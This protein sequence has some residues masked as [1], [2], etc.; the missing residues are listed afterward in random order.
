MTKFGGLVTDESASSISTSPLEVKFSFKT[1]KP[2]GLR[3]FLKKKKVTLK[4]E[5]S[6]YLWLDL[7]ATFK[8]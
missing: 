2:F 6:E 4:M 3:P 7:L 5:N 1:I 8:K